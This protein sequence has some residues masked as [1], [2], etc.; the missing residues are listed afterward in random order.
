MSTGFDAC[1]KPPSG[2]NNHKAF[3]PRRQQRDH[4]AYYELNPNLERRV[5]VKSDTF[6]ISI[7][8]PTDST[9]SKTE[10]SGPKTL[11]SVL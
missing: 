6:T 8:Q 1:L 2:D 11:K 10:I 9:Y 5:V 7:M 3:Y 4:G